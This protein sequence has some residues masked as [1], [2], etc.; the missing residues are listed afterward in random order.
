MW[1]AGWEHRGIDITLDTAACPGWPLNT[2]ANYS[3]VESASGQEGGEHNWTRQIIGHSG[4]FQS[5]HQK[6]FEK[7]IITRGH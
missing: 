7:F 4:S 5:R 6:L 1:G 2:T 3:L